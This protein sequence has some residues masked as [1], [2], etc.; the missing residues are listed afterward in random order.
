M[1]IRL[2]YNCDA[3][4]SGSVCCYC[5]N[6]IFDAPIIITDGETFGVAHA[7]CHLNSL[8]NDADKADD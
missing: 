7:S 1:N 2:Y 3:D 4:L 5:D 6:P 8:S